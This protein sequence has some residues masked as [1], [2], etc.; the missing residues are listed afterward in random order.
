M[1]ELQDIMTRDVIALDPEM[2][3][4]EALE[5]LT[6]RHI[7]GAPVVEAARVVGVLSAMDI[8]EFLATT[9]GVPDVIDAV[10]GDPR[11]LDDPAEGSAPYFIDFWSDADDDVT[12]RF[13]DPPR[14][15]VT[16]SPCT[17]SLRR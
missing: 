8:I 2:S 16:C 12:E 11:A 5:I 7:S 4:R 13:S 9:P 10:E 17:P 15:R 3:L 1:L 6:T 14:R